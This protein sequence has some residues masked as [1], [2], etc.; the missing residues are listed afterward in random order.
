M[1]RFDDE[2]IEGD[3]HRS[4]ESIRQVLLEDREVLEALDLSPGEVKENVTVEGVGVNGLAPGTRLALGDVV[5]EV[6]KEC[7]P[8]SR[9]EE[10]RDGLQA[11]LQGK[12]GTLAR[13]ITPGFVRVGDPVMVQQLEGTVS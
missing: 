6:T 10:I 1:A 2:G 3:E 11:A 8:C 7:G 4:P 9:M 13:V 12:R 5:L